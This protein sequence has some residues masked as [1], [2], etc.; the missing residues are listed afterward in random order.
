MSSQPFDAIPPVSRS[1][2]ADLT[3]DQVQLFT[4][5]NQLGLHHTTYDHKPVFSV[6]ESDYLKDHIPGTHCRSLL[7]T[8]KTGQFWMVS[9][10]DETVIDLK[11]LS[12]ALQTPRFSF[13]KAEHM[14]EILHVTPGSL[15]PYAL[16]FDLNHQVQFILDESLMTQTDCVFHPL[17]NTQSTIL[18]TTDLVTFAIHTGHPPRIMA[19]SPANA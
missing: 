17:Q 4:T 1:L 8:N 19:L 9:A 14:V 16:L 15:T 7:L 3:P 18:P 2:L 5:L 11:Y 13:A 12:D 10:A 6:R